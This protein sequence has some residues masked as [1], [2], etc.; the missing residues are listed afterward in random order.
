MFDRFNLTGSEN[1]AFLNS[2]E[3]SSTECGRHLHWICSKPFKQWGAMFAYRL[4]HHG[5]QGNSCRWMLLY[6]QMF[7]IRTFV[8]KNLQWFW[9]LSSKQDC[10]RKAGKLQD[11]LHCRT[12]LLWPENITSWWIFMSKMEK[13]DFKPFEC[14]L[15]FFK[16]KNNIIARFRV[17]IYCRM[18]SND[19]CPSRICTIRRN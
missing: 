3:V 13:N 4:S 17:I 11:Y 15:Y 1:C 7:A 9:K 12:P 6:G 14:T 2:T 18:T 19:E 10:G 16:F 8:E 5:T